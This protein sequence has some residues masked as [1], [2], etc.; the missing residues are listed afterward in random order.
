MTEKKIENLVILL[1]IIFS[2]YCAL[3]NGASL[4]VPFEMRMGKERLKYLFSLGAYSDYDFKDVRFYPGFYNTFS[5][6]ITKMF[7][8][9]YEIQIWSLINLTFSFFTAVGIGKITEKLF[10]KK[11]GKIVFLLCF[12]N[13]IFFG[14][15]SINCKDTIIAFA[16][17]WLTYL[18]LRYFETQHLKRGNKYVFL[19][20]LVLGLGAGVR[21]V[22]VATLIP[23]FFLLLLEI[24]FFKKIINSKFSVKKFCFDL[25][26]VLAIAYF[27]IIAF[28]PHTHQNIIILP[29]KLFFE[30]LNFSFGWPWILFN[31]SYYFTD[32][33]PKY[34]LITNLLY[35]TPEFI[36][37]SYAAFI[38][39]F[40]SNK[41][42][43]T[44]Q[45]NFFKTKIFF[46]LFILIFPNLL[47]FINPYK[48]Y[49]GL[50][51]FLYLIPYLC[52][53]PGL[54]IYYLFYNFKTK[55]SKVFLLTISPFFL[56]Y[57]FIFISLTP[58][59]YTYLNILVGNYSEASKKF[60]NDYWAVSIKELVKN[61]SY[62]KSLLNTDKKVKMAFCGGHYKQTKPMLEAIKNFN[63][64]AVDYRSE[65]Y[66]YVIMT[67]RSQGDKNHE[68]IE[69]VSSCFE[70]FK[71]EDV[72]SVKRNGLILSILRKKL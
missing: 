21:I 28:W 23:L 50:R 49:D 55:I 66:D 64:E 27:L 32:A 68:L 70:T 17:V 56:Y 61:I 16:N 14:H 57:L 52:I 30:S 33:V 19:A 3:I 47:I 20:G 39:L 45:F 62:E 44:S 37:L 1:L 72:I 29:F 41:Y 8:A 67:N 60:E 18:L 4:D 40:F 31:G 22:F 34:Y 26:I 7:P 42:F 58:Y 35:K 12:L 54:F 43:F 13:P 5:I 46:I 2:I 53:I 9:K 15:M 63:F 11:V 65:E 25:I 36:L 10:N 51:L 71:G 6:F 59:H 69:K 38:Y 24:L 48:L